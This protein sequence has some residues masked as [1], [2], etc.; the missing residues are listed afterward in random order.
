[1]LSKEDVLV[2]YAAKTDYHKING[3]KHTHDY[4]NFWGSEIQLI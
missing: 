3:L 2:L 1:M 4:Y